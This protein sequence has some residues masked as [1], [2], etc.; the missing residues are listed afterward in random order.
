M[1][2]L[3]D[4]LWKLNGGGKIAIDQQ[5]LVN[6]RANLVKAG[7]DLEQFLGS[8]AT[9]IDGS[10]TIDDK[11][12]DGKKID[13]LIQKLQDQGINTQWLEDFRKRLGGI[14]GVAER[15]AKLMDAGIGGAFRILMSAI[16]G[17][18]VTLGRCGQRGHYAP[19]NEASR[20]VWRHCEV[21]RDEQN[22]G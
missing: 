13:E 1:E 7:V 6:L 3:D 17:V 15:T 11:S 2:M 21:H 20:C 19:Y 14:N 12:I 9:T 16:E 8:K 4:F 22:P 10:I 5:D 18:G